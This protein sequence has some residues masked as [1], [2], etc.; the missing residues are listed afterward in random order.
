MASIVSRFL[1]AAAGTGTSSVASGET[2]LAFG[3]TVGVTRSRALSL[4]AVSRSRDV[5]CSLT[6]SLPIRQYGTAWNGEDLEEIP[7]PPEPWMIQ[8]E[9]DVPRSVTMAWLT[10]DLMFHGRAYLYTTETYA[11]GMPARFQWLP[12]EDVQLVASSFRG[13]RPI[14]KVS[15]ITYLG[16]ILDPRLVHIFYSPYEPFLATAAR[17]V[18]IAERLDAAAERYAVNDTPPGHLKQR[19]G[20]PLD[21]DEMVEMASEWSL[22]RQ[23]GRTAFA[24]EEVDWIE[25]TMDPSRLQLIEARQYAALELARH[26]NV[27]PWICGISTGGMTYQNATQAK[28]DAVTF[29][30]LGFIEALEQG[31]SSN[32]ITPRGRV[33]RLDRTAWTDNPLDANMDNRQT[34]QERTPVPQERTP[35]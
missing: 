26:A 16:N 30:A 29:G 8:P 31:F 15:E 20:Q 25:S 18:R 17:S 33:V 10:D 14:G 28:A 11:N 21:H 9:K 2:A 22:A 6:G 12:A 32:T 3:S 24:P 1:T 34:R 27:P 4:G 35:A 19:K 23:E 13:N 5:L 7:L